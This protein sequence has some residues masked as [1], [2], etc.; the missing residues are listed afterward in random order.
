MAEETVVKQ[1][2]LKKPEDTARLEKVK[3]DVIIQTSE[4]K[5]VPF[6]TENPTGGQRVAK[7]QV[8]EF[9]TFSTTQGRIRALNT[10]TGEVVN[11]VILATTRVQNL[12][13]PTEAK[14]LAKK[15]GF[16]IS[17][18]V[19]KE[20]AA[21]RSVEKKLA[22]KG[23][24][25]PVSDQT[26]ATGVVKKEISPG[27]FKTV[28]T[29]SRLAGSSGKVTV[30]EK[31]PAEKPPSDTLI[32][33]Q[34][35][36]RR[37]LTQAFEQ[38]KQ[39]VKTI[40][41]TN[42]ERKPVFHISAGLGQPAIPVNIPKI[43]PNPFGPEIPLINPFRVGKISQTISPPGTVPDF[44]KASRKTIENTRF[45][46]KQLSNF[47]SSFSLG[48]EIG[49]NLPSD[50]AVF[51]SD[52]SQSPTKNIQGRNRSN[53]TQYF[54]HIPFELANVLKG[55][56]P[57][58]RSYKGFVSGL[59][60]V[61]PGRRASQIPGKGFISSTGRGILQSVQT[62]IDRPFLTGALIAA[63]LLAPE[64]LAFAAARVGISTIA[65]FSVSNVVT[66]GL[67][68]GGVAL[69]G[70]E[71]KSRVDR[72]Q[73][74]S[75]A[76]GEV[77]GPVIVYGGLLA[78]PSLVRS[79][80][81]AFTTPR[82]SRVV[83]VESLGG[84]ALGGRLLSSEVAG[85][86][87]A[88]G[89][90]AESEV[91]SVADVLLRRSGQRVVSRVSVDTPAQYGVI[92]DGI[93]DFPS[94]VLSRFSAES[95]VV[96]DVRVT[97]DYSSLT[98]RP[99]LGLSQPALKR[100]F[101]FGPS[102]K[103]SG[104]VVSFS[105]KVP[106]L[107][108]DVVALQQRVRYASRIEKPDYSRLTK[109]PE[110][111]L[112]VP[113]IVSSRSG[114]KEYLQVGRARVSP[115]QVQVF[116][117][118]QA[119]GSPSGGLARI[120]PPEFLRARTLFGKSRDVVL[121][122][123]RFESLEFSPTPVE[124]GAR[125]VVTNRLVRDVEPFITFSDVGER[126]EFTGA[127]TPQIGPGPGPGVLDLTRIPGE[128]SRVNVEFLRTARFQREVSQKTFIRDFK[129]TDVGLFRTKI[130]NRPSGLLE[131]FLFEPEAAPSRLRGKAAIAPE[132]PR[133]KD[134][135]QSLRRESSSEPSELSVI[136]EGVLEN[137][138]RDFTNV[139]QAGR[140]AGV[141]GIVEDLSIGA[142]QVSAPFK[143]PNIGAAF[144]TGR[145][146][147]AI[148]SSQEPVFEGL[149]LQQNSIFQFGT[150]EFAGPDIQQS[151]LLNQERPSR[152]RFRQ[153]SIAASIKGPLQT[154]RQEIITFPVIA[155]VPVENVGQT[156]TQ[157]VEQNI[158]PVPATPGR[159]PVTPFT[160]FGNI[161]P[162]KIFTPPT[163]FPPYFLIDEP[164]GKDSFLKRV[165]GGRYAPDVFSLVFN[166]R[167]PLS[168]RTLAG[169]GNLTGFELRPVPLRSRGFGGQISGELSS[170][171]GRSR[172][173]NP[174]SKVLLQSSS[175]QRKPSKKKVRGQ[176][177]F[178]A[179]ASRV[180]G[181]SPSFERFAQQLRRFGR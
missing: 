34:E 78:T 163:F 121:L 132:R 145:K 55:L 104:A 66:G 152:Q 110:L 11:P 15:R 86:K 125:R 43:S 51:G 62:A 180:F 24:D 42:Q 89:F 113:E 14:E 35:K 46:Q 142:A 168:K 117:G 39:K 37:E 10:K 153:P 54:R 77:L 92:R 135:F 88:G 48:R 68:T 100:D 71:V 44:R 165:S 32:A 97:P 23:S 126:F 75:Q 91:R 103:S 31:S 108:D 156:P 119:S 101:V 150:L 80:Y 56:S 154:S 120:T 143:L 16:D 36:A 122:S 29:G 5:R 127:R 17:Q 131:E 116:L 63:P 134:L 115:D 9:V 98:P 83:D 53:Q 155:Q 90:V 72:G 172:L 45:Y 22:K 123:E 178:F 175:R 70:S 177:L 13:G 76:T 112:S 141:V 114:V 144:A 136:S 38:K 109:V 85:I 25:R 146:A 64:A 140:T 174:F 57:Q 67:I 162:P 19:D 157:I 41:R 58:D 128:K 107:P 102:R 40:K 27:V 93:V 18:R 137:N 3:G 20:V 147:E 133:R 28:K 1:E 74:I 111:Q 30:V 12:P 151:T 138:L 49:R 52:F 176:Q 129:P 96:R 6:I 160:P 33:A 65:G 164:T 159:P 4:G 169:R 179:Q 79:T 161:P 149:A 171:L 73:P 26:K 105:G 82:F 47:R 81:S 170:L 167:A 173:K 130:V 139:A 166:V 84:E 118:Q 61:E 158:V 60:S 21:G 94:G 106:G 8:G 124:V 99:D 7:K 2:D 50:V 95:R 87:G 59:A 181:S 148:T 69:T